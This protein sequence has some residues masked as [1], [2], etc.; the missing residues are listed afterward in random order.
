MF[1]QHM[2]NLSNITSND[3]NQVIIDGTDLY[4]YITHTSGQN[5][6]LS[7]RDLPTNLQEWN[8][9]I[10]GNIEYHF[11]R[12]YGPVSGVVNSDARQSSFVDA[13]SNAISILLTI[14]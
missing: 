5:G 12:F 4:R 2:P 9:Q 3:I 1:M 7:H 14:S 11:D 13:F 8:E 6:Y 10:T